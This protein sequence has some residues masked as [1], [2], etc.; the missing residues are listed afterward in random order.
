[1]PGEDL[2][3]HLPNCAVLFLGKDDLFPYSIFYYR[4]EG[5]TTDVKASPDDRQIV[6]IILSKVRLNQSI[7]A[8][9]FVYNPRL[10]FTDETEKLLAKLGL[11]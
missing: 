10:K 8:G 1:M 9:K 3:E 2:P 11:K 7:P 4:L 5:T 6:Q